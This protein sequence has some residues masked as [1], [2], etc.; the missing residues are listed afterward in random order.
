MLLTCWRYRQARG[1]TSELLLKA[2]CEHIRASARRRPAGHA[3][4]CIQDTEGQIAHRHR[5]SGLVMISFLAGERAR[6]P[7]P[8]QPSRPRLLASAR[9]STGTAARAG[10]SA[11]E[12][13]DA[14]SS[15]GGCRLPPAG[16]AGAA[17]T[18]STKRSL[19]QCSPPT[20]NRRQL[21][22]AALSTAATAVVGAVQLPAA[23]AAPAAE[24][25]T[26]A[27]NR[28][29]EAKVRMSLHLLPWLRVIRQHMVPLIVSIQSHR[30]YGGPSVDVLP[31][32]SPRCSPPSVA[33]PCSAAPASAFG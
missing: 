19:E 4:A 20:L 22:S 28:L 6:T 31:H 26:A 18:S 29:R 14:A 10:S 32:A 25:P 3:A 15:S 21:G 30:C 9:R 7:C 23:A 11:V 27:V 13:S 12:S 5:I 8:Q 1:Q 33:A 16:A 2:I 24:G 17:G